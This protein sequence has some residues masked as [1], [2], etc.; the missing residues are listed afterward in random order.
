MQSNRSY[1]S[2]I[3]D[4]GEDCD[5]LKYLRY[6][7]ATFAVQLEL[8]AAGDERLLYGN[9]KDKKDGVWIY[10]TLLNGGAKHLTTKPSHHP[11]PR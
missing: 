2:L 10:F 5:L 11:M 1:E 3:Q 6:N 4:L 8:D 7:L 9:T